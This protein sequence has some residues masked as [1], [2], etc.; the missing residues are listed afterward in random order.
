MAN[1]PKEIDFTMPSGLR[2]RT[3]DILLDGSAMILDRDGELVASFDPRRGEWRGTLAGDAPTIV[4]SHDVA[5]RIV[6][7]LAKGQSE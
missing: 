6:A 4:L 7:G 1:D 2:I 3:M 5:A